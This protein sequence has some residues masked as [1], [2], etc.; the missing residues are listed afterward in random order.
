MMAAVRRALRTVELLTHTS[1]SSAS[2]AESKVG[3]EIIMKYSCVKWA[4][5]R[6]LPTVQHSSLIY[7]CFLIFA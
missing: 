6:L 2:I 4:V 3:E 1:A 5:N 7:F